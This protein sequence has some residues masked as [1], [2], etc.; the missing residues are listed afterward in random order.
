MNISPHSN[1]PK[2]YVIKKFYEYG[3]GVEYLKSNDSYHCSCPIC[4]E[5]KSF[6]KK[7][8]CW[9]IPSKNLIYCHNCGW[10]SRPLKWIMRAGDI[11][12][13]DIQNELINEEYTIINLDKKRFD[14]INFDNL[15][16]NKNDE[17]LPIDSIDLTNNLQLEYYKNNSVVKKALMYIESRK[18]NTAVN[19]PSK[20]FI[21]LSDRVHKNRL[22][23]PFYNDNGEITF[24]QSRAIGASHDVNLENVKYLGKKHAQKSVFNLDKINDSIE[25]IF[26]FEGP[27]DAC[28]IKNGIAIAGITP[29]REK[30]FTEVQ[31]SQLESYRFNHH[32]IWVLDSQW[33]DDAAYNKTKVLLENGESVFIWPEVIG[34]QYKDFNELCVAM[35]KNEIP[36]NAV[37]ENTLTGK[38]GLIKYNLLMKNR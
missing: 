27:I 13:N 23:I 25:E 15:I 36:I 29:S 9:Y 7:K 5:G 19:K 38:L 37:K 30:S 22:V 14:S 35:N 4:M 28:F 21:S 16:E 12:Y 26:I 34:K 24:Y 20:F 33:I 17:V 3:Y 10:S 11:T 1:L 32:F 8:R 31:E 18:L 2:E 6:G